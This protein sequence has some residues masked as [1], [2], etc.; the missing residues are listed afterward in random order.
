MSKSNTGVEG[1][2][3]KDDK[4]PGYHAKIMYNY[5]AHTKYFSVNKYGKEEAFRLAVEWLEAEKGRLRARYAGYG[6]V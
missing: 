2:C 3:F 6:R 4:C 5:T 1:V